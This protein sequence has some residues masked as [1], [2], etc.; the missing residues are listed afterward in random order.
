MIKKRTK[1]RQSTAKYSRGSENRGF[2]RFIHM[3]FAKRATCTQSLLAALWIRCSCS[4]GSHVFK[5][6]QRFDHF[7]IYCTLWIEGRWAEV[8]HKGC[9]Q[10][11]WV[12]LWIK[13]WWS[14]YGAVGAGVCG[15]CSKF[16]QLAPASSRAKPAPTRSTRPLWERA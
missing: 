14:R 9:P 6:L 13:C 8:F 3:G 11:L 7:L 4:A 5:G 12:W 10:L 1:P 16:V 15:C 2:R